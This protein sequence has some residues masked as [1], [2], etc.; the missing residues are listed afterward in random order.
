MMNIIE[1]NALPI[2][3]A[4]AMILAFGIIASGHATDG[5]SFLSVLYTVIGGLTGAHFV[6]KSQS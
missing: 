2:V 6:G 1:Q 5:A 3:A 4:F